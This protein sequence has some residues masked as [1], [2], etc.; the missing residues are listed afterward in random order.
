MKYCPTCRSE[1]ESHIDTCADCKVGLVDRL[2]LTPTPDPLSKI[3]V[4]C[5]EPLPRAKIIVAGLNS[6]GIPAEIDDEVSALMTPQLAEVKISVPEEF[7]ED[8]R[9]ALDEFRR[10]DC[11][12]EDD[13][14]IA[15]EGDAGTREP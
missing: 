9:K 1:Y 3:V 11:R 15:G 12:I 6:R 14:E 8:A 4:L 10:H 5:W 2:P 7:A 13:E